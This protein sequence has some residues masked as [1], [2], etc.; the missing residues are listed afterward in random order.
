MSLSAARRSGSSS[1]AKWSRAKALV[2]SGL[3]GTL[4]VASLA[5]SVWRFDRELSFYGDDDAH[6]LILGKSLSEGW[7]YRVFTDPLQPR[8]TLFP[9]G[10][11]LLIATLAT[12][13]GN[14]SLQALVIPAK[15]LTL[16]LYLGVICLLYQV[17]R[18]R[19][20]PLV[21]LAATTLSALHPDVVRMG[22][23]VMSEVPFL[24]FTLLGIL[25]FERLLLPTRGVAG[26]WRIG[27][28]IIATA[29]LVWPVYLR[30]IGIALPVGALL[31]LAR[32]RRFHD[33]LLV[34]V[35][36]VVLLLPLIAHNRPETRP[37]SGVT[38]IELLL[39]RGGYGLASSV[40]LPGEIP[41]VITLG[42]VLRELAGRVRAGVWF[43]RQAIPAMILDPSTGDAMAKSLPIEFLG[44][45][46][47][48]SGYLRRLRSG[49]T[50][51]DLYIALY[52]IV[53]LVWQFRFTRYVVP[54]LP[55]FILYAVKGLEGWVGVAA[56]LA[57][58]SARRFLVVAGI[59][60]ACAANLSLAYRRHAADA[61]LAATPV[62]ERNWGNWRTGYFR[63]TAWISRHTRDDV[64]VYCLRPR[65]MSVVTGRRAGT[66]MLASSDELVKRIRSQRQAYL[67]EDGSDFARRYLRPAL[68]ALE[69]VR[70]LELADA[71][72][73]ETRIWRVLNNR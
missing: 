67:L 4:L 18:R 2:V 6:Y 30:P 23:E 36:T 7:G 68:E 56:R 42:T 50:L 28:A 73:G 15:I 40:E 37:G 29:V 59:L 33:A 70:A 46:L 22:G 66:Y 64:V 53:L 8:H 17:E 45:A 71:Q 31:L 20:A 49:L 27:R 65:H 63:A 26:P 32:R 54:V 61:A 38:Q 72:G 51:S 39:A 44:L 34:G 11:P 55:F 60:V 14:P 48:A 57:P 47:I 3:V 19:E 52:T 58:P 13:L 41:P 35:A 16:V 12:A 62:V 9:P 43:Y 25:A 69:A 5:I 21:V 24:F 1:A 10:Y